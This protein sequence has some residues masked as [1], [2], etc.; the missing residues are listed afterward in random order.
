MTTSIEKLAE[1][2]NELVR[3]IEKGGNLRRVEMLR[4]L[5]GAC[6]AFTALL[7]DSSVAQML[8]NSYPLSRN[9]LSDLLD[10]VNQFKGEFI[11]VESK[12][13][14]SA[15][16][17]YR[18]R[19]MLLRQATYFRTKEA[20]GA[21][22]REIP[23]LAEIQSARDLIC[24]LAAALREPDEDGARKRE[25]RQRMR[26]VLFVSAGVATVAVDSAI[27]TANPVVSG[28]SMLFGA[29]IFNRGRAD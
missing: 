26:R 16:L 9:E 19:K 24:S 21:A 18:S 22:H 23:A 3:L 25:I 1:S 5:D 27:V 17:D 8:E 13:L 4:A 6:A 14:R 12:A 20:K 2:V 29:D 15:G 28:I 11:S 10:N 7:A